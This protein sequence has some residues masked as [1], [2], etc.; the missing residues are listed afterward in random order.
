MGFVFAIASF[1]PFDYRDVTS[2][3]QWSTYQLTGSGYRDP[4]EVISRFISRTLPTYVDYSTDYIQYQIAGTLYR[5]RAYANQ[6]Y[7]DDIYDRCN[8]YYLGRADYYCRQYGY[9]GNSPYYY[10]VAIGR[11]PSTPAP[12]TPG[13]TRPAL[14]KKLV[15]DPST[16]DEGIKIQKPEQRSP[17][18]NAEIQRAWWDLQ[19]RSADKGSSTAT[20]FRGG[21]RGDPQTPSPTDFRNVPV[22]PRIN[23]RSESQEERMPQRRFEPSPQPRYEPENSRRFEAPVIRA[24]PIQRNEPVMRSEPARSEPIMRVEPVQRSEPAPREFHP[25]PQ[26]PPPPP[27]PP[28]PV[29]RGDPAPRTLP[30]APPPPPPPAS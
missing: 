27:P 25:A 6:G 17:A 5:P 19:R 10:P 2:A 12:R 22:Q 16:K 21:V 4:Y 9:F 11:A 1:E 29:D 13:K 26:P 18:G 23:V 30:S 24:E 3:G 15:P 14:P 20:V 7:F 28:A 8:R